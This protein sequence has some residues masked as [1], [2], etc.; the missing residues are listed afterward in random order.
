MSADLPDD[1]PLDA[2]LRAAL[3]HAPDRDQR[4]PAAVRAAVLQAAHAAVPRR[5]SLWRRWLGLDRGWDSPRLWTAVAGV[6]GV[7]LALNLAWHLSTS[8][9]ASRDTARRDEAPMAAA[10]AASEASPAPVAPM[11]AAQVAEATPAEPPRRESRLRQAD[12]PPPSGA[13]VAEEKRRAAAPP[14][15]LEAT[16]VAPPP[17]PAPVAAA[18]PIP[19][20]TP[21]VPAP[22]AAPL[23]AE[24]VVAAPTAPGQA[25]D[26]RMADAAPPAAKAAARALPD[27]AS[28]PLGMAIAGPWPAPLAPLA[29]ALAVDGAWPAAGWQVT[30]RAGVAGPSKAWWQ[31]ML[32]ATAGRWQAQPGPLRADALAAPAWRVDAPDGGHFTLTLVGRTVWL[33]AGDATWRAS[34]V[35]PWP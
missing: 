33:Q 28:T 14:A 31:A 21:P 30:G 4:P 23:P 17:V 9:E 27:Q 34:P 18:A 5:P 12:L 8:P 26:R 7:G 29:Q 19:A 15:R 32:Q 13:P 10:Q 24:S 1:P 2:P 35:P 25:A 11:A 22:A 6:A 20:A 16:N 3:A